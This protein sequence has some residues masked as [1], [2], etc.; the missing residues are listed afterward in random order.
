MILFGLLSLGVRL[1]VGWTGLHDSVWSAQSRR[2]SVCGTD[3][4]T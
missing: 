3:R 1:S 2:V 4:V